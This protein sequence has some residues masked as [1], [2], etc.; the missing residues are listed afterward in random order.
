MRRAVNN[1]LLSGRSSFYSCSNRLKAKLPR[2][3]LDNEP[4][5][6]WFFA[7]GADPNIKNFLGDTPL[8]FAIRYLSLSEVTA[9]VQH[10]AKSWCSNALQTCATFNLPQSID[11]AVVM[12]EQGADI[13][14]VSFD[15]RR[16]LDAEA[17]RQGH[18]TS[19]HELDVETI[20]EHWKMV[21]LSFKEDKTSALH[22][23]VLCSNKEMIKFLLKRGADPDLRIRAG[24]ATPREL[25]ERFQSN[26]FPDI[27][28]PF[29][30]SVNL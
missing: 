6:T 11:K 24:D 9:L 7:H 15:S 20:S 25:A 19:V 3:V 29:H 26:G 28:Q 5:R 27:I 30:P 1:F 21:P 18:I 8:D 10:G 13:N 14:G 16:G 17:Y 23:A 22:N 2:F 4:L 12:L